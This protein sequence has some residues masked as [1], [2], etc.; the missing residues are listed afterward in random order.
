MLL[1]FKNDNNEVK[2]YIKYYVNV[3]VFDKQQYYDKMILY[4]VVV[5]V[6]NNRLVIL[7]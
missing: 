1:V 3:V 4:N 7:W 6:K 2:C 5:F